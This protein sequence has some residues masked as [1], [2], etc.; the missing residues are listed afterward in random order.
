MIKAI[1]F[2]F[3]GV[4]HDTLDLAYKINLKIGKKISLAEYK[5]AFNGNIYQHKKFTM[6]RAKKYFKLQNQEFKKLLIKQEI[7]DEL[8]KLKLNYDL[9]I[10]SSN[11]EVALNDYFQNNKIDHIFK[12]VLGLESHKLKKDKFKVL[13][14]KYQLNKNN[15]LFI[16]DTLGDILEANEIG[17]KTIA[18]DFGFHERVRL[19][20]GKPLKIISDFRELLPE[21][22]KLNK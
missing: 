6:Q 19:K 8:L 3:D 4:I 10:I 16:T 14:E 2:D 17:L 9:F 7:K 22:N 21:I 15:C 12:E 20:K 13:M 5:D 1:I 11:M 18:V